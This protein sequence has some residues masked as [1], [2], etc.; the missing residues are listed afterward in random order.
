MEILMEYFAKG[1]MTMLMIAMPCVLTAAAIGLVVGILQAV[2]QVQEQTIAA[3]PKIFTVF[4]V[5][6][7]LGSTYVKMLTNYFIEGANLAFEVVPKEDSFVLP[8]DYYNYTK[9]FIDEIKTDVKKDMTPMSHILK[10]T[11]RPQGTA[12]KDKFNFLRN[13]AT[14]VPTPNLVER[15]KIME[16]RR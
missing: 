1:L 9:P 12:Q 5:I 16:N 10:N 3:A 7:L 13:G 14:E 4:L 2:T 11:T 6:I 15:K 8:S